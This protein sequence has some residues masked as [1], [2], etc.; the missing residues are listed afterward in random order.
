ML[1]T[2]GWPKDGQVLST[3]LT[4]MKSNL[5]AA[6]ITFDTGRNHQERFID[7]RLQPSPNEPSRPSQSVLI[8]RVLEPITETVNAS[9]GDAVVPNGPDSTD[10]GHGGRRDRRD[11][12][13]TG[14]TAAIGDDD[15]WVM[16]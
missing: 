2:H 14:A 1:R 16:P 6:G 13:R 3:T 11:Y 12:H 5:K 4:R 8:P 9:A 10:L 15:E 7:I